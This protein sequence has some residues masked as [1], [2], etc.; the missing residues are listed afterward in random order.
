MRITLKQKIFLAFGLILFFFGLNAVLSVHTLNQNRKIMAEINMGLSP[1]KESITDFRFLIKNNEMLFSNLINN[2]EDAVALGEFL[3]FEKE[4]SDLCR[5]KLFSSAKKIQNA[6]VLKNAELLL[7][8]YFKIVARQ[9]N[10]LS[11][12]VQNNRL[13]ID[14][15]NEDLKD[16]ILADYKNRV[17]P[18][19]EKLKLKISKYQSAID[20]IM[21]EKED[22]LASKGENLRTYVVVMGLSL[23]L[24]CLVITFYFSNTVIGSI[25]DIRKLL[26]KISVGEIPANNI[27]SKS[28]DEIGQIYDAISALVAGLKRTTVFAYNIGNG[29]LD[30]KFEPLSENDTLGQ[31]LLDMR[32]SLKLAAEKDDEQNMIV[33]SIAEVSSILSS[34][35]DLQTI[36]DRII[37]YLCEKTN[38]VQGAFY[39]V[40]VESEQ[41]EIN[42]LSAYAY[43]RKKYITKTFKKGYGLVG[44]AVAE[45]DLVHRTEIPKDYVSIKSGILGDKKPTSILVMPLITNEEAYGAIE[46]ASIYKYSSRQINLIREISEVIARSI[47]NIQVNERTRRLL[48]ESQKMSSE[49]KEQSVMLQQNAEE[50]EATQ[51]ELKRT[52]IK[53]EEQIN[54]V[55]KSQKKINVLLQNSSEIIS[56]VNEK[57]EISYVSPSVKSIA[58]YEGD[59]LLNTLITD[60]ISFEYHEEFY[61]MIEKVINNSSESFTI[62]Y[63]Y[64]KKNGEYIWMEATAKNLLK[65]EAINGIVINSRDITLRKL[66]EKESRMR[67][68][69]QSLSEN[70]PDLICRLNTEGVFYY[71]NPVIEKLTKVVKDQFEQKSFYDTPLAESVINEWKGILEKV[72]VDQSKVSTEMVFPTDEGKVIMSVNAIPEFGENENLES[73]LLVSSDIT[74]RKEIEI[75]IQ[76]KNKKITES[77]NYAKRIQSAILPDNELISRYLP[78]SFILYKPRDVVSGDFPWFMKI[79]DIIYIAAVDCTGHG[80]PGA[81]LSL[82]GYFVLN[83][84]VKSQK[85]TDTGPILDLLDAGVTSTLRQDEKG[86]TKDG[87]DISLVK[88]DTKNRVVQYSGAH[89]PLYVMKNNELVEFKGDKFPIG[90]GVFRNQTNFTTHTISIENGDSI[91]FCSDGY[92]DQF[93]GPENRKLSPARIRNLI[94]EYS[95]AP[96]NQLHDLFDEMFMDWKGQNKQTDDVL[97]IGIRF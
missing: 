86:D 16:Q 23:I 6:D 30:A 84:V 12:F 80:V 70:S 11:S 41:K 53:L 87:M 15:I 5:E 74:E 20:A 31:A 4:E 28:K 88:I 38:S 64:L 34:N 44:Q 56:I 45:M 29:E 94:S 22:E 47:F 18:E 95:S 46:F 72:I 7:D 32:E 25:D 92:P 90:G 78:D 62:E 57:G 3:K 39:L 49:L 27:V 97:L 24:I 79:G 61:S 63:A 76:N 77:I 58:E 21:T 96:M 17:K 33:S 81:L 14:D 55:F 2:P 40:N 52:N 42:M 91:F 43:N 82:I 73:I 13:V 59:E 67:S 26:D 9:Q 10:I 48:A 54:E 8:D 83:D 1:L 68:Q 75:E 60:K 35:E 51:E 65:D 85:V 37:K 66:A 71:V 19:F 36:S 89:R 93:G 50:M 69:M